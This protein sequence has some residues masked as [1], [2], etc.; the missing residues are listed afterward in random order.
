MRARRPTPA[1]ASPSAIETGSWRLN[2]LAGRERGYFL[3]SV[4]LVLVVVLLVIVIFSLRLMNRPGP[5][6][7]RLSERYHELNARD[8]LS[9]AERAELELEKC[10]FKRD[11]LARYEKEERPEFEAA[12]TEYR[13]SCAQ[14]LPR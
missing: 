12:E 1:T 11:L 10:R 5:A 13:Q 8:D 7:V 3:S 9:A 4:N 6:E 14:R 2:A